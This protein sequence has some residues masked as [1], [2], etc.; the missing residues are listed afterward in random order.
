MGKGYE[1]AMEQLSS[2]SICF[3]F[4]GCNGFLT[5]RRGASCC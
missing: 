2:S 1:E 4:S 3:L 5:A